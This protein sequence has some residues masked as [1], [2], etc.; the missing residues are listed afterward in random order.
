MTESLSLRIERLLTGD[1]GRPHCDACLALRFQQ[2]LAD[3]R[4]AAIRLAG[5][6]GW[7]RTVNVCSG[8]CQR[9]VEMTVRQR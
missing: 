4:A 8:G 1:A 9:P 7:M 6:R 3:T 5:E 2:T